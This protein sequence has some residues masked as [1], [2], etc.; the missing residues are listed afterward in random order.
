M[1]K[2]FSVLALSVL[3]CSCSALYTDYKE[4]TMPVVDS[5]A[6][7]SMFVGEAIASKYYQSFNDENLNKVVEK[8]LVH[9]LDFKKAYVNVQKALL[10]VDL[11]KT[12]DH[13]SAT[14]Q[15]GADT[16]RALD[17]HDSTHKSS[18][19]SLSLSY[20][21]DLFGKIKAQD[22]EAIENYKATAYDYLA[23]RL[24]VI[25]TTANAYFQYAYAKEAVAIGL[26]DLED[27]KV[28]LDLV[29]KKYQ[30]GAADSLDLDDATINHLKVQQALDK[31]ENALAKA[32]TALTT[33]LGEMPNLDETTSKLDDVL[34]PKFS[35]DVPLKL[36]E[37]RPDLKKDEAL[38]KKAY[39]SYNYKKMAFF[40]DLTLSAAISS[41]DTNTFARFFSNPIG[42]LGA[43]I[44]LPFLN[45]NKL[46][47]EKKSAYKDI[48][49]TELNFVSDYIKAVQE[50]YDGISDVLYNQKSLQNTHDSYILSVR[51]YERYKLRYEAGIVSLTDFLSSADQMRNAKIS[52]LEAKLNNL[53]STVSLMTALGGDRV[54]DIQNIQ[55]ITK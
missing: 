5:Y 37:N 32:K 36:L 26:E 43:A 20:Q 34:V 17:H 13:P 12:N 18:N 11:A 15:L 25:E 29:T 48:E 46:N 45:F 9:N 16:K 14:A 40:P 47:I 55:G 23:M 8:A 53:S 6:G 31:R 51:N 10:N 52:Y 33:L 38:L 22:E 49:L 28:R 19:T 7:A 54:V 39:A 24:T 4:P 35:T 30:A 44:T 3:L 42:T 41:G 50:V 27:S 2:S 21:I 1:R